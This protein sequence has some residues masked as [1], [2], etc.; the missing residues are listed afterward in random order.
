MTESRLL[1]IMA[2]VVRVP[3]KSAHHA[4]AIATGWGEAGTIRSLSRLSP[5]GTSEAPAIESLAG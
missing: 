5:S 3:E 4:A 1:I 2:D